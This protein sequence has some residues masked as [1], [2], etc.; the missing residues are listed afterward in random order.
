MLRNVGGRWR[1]KPRSFVPHETDEEA[2]SISGEQTVKASVIESTV[3]PSDSDLVLDDSWMTQLQSLDALVS[4]I[5]LARPGVEQCAREL[6]NK[7]LCVFADPQLD[8]AHIHL[9]LPVN[10]AGHKGELIS[11]VGWLLECVTGARSGELAQGT[12]FV[13]PC[14]VATAPWQEVSVK[15]GVLDRAIKRAQAQFP[16]QYLHQVR[17]FHLGPVRQH[18]RQLEPGPLSCSIRDRQLRML[19]TTERRRNVINPQA[20][21]MLEQLLN[22]PLQRLRSQL[23]HEAVQVCSVHLEGDPSQS[24]VVL[25]NTMVFHQPAH[26]DGPVVFWSAVKGLRVYNSLAVLEAHFNQW[27]RRSKEQHDWLALLAAEDRALVSSFLKRASAPLIRIETQAIED[28]FISELQRMEQR[29]QYQ[30]IE[31]ALLFAKRLLLDNAATVAVTHAVEIT[32]ANTTIL[33]TYSIKLQALFFEASLPDWIRKASD[34]ELNVYSELVAYYFRT[35][36]T[37]HDFLFGVPKLREFAREKLLM[38]LNI[39]F[40]NQTFDPDTIIV[41][42]FRYITAGTIGADVL[43]ALPAATEDYSET[44]TDFVLGHIGASDGFSLSVSSTDAQQTLTGFT[45]PYLNTLVRTLDIGGNYQNILEEKLSSSSADYAKRLG[46]FCD[47]LPAQM[48]ETAFQQKLEGILSNLAW[49]YV[50]RVVNMPDNLARLPVFGTTVVLRPFKLVAAPGWQADLASGIYLFGP[51]DSTQGPLVLHAIFHDAF[52]FKEFANEAELLLA[53][54]SDSELQELILQRLSPQARDRYDYGGFR[55][56]HL[57]SG[58]VTTWDS[59]PLIPAPPTLSQEAVEGNALQFFFRDTITVMKL[60]AKNQ[61]VTAA[62]AS[63]SA[64]TYLLTL[65]GEQAFT[66]LPGKL[67][68]LV[69]AWQSGSWFQASFTAASAQRWGKALSEFSAGLAM[70]LSSRAA[71]EEELVIDSEE[72]AQELSLPQPTDF[73]WQNNN[74]NAELNARLRTFEVIDVELKTL[75]KDPLLNLYGDHSAD[76]YYAAVG[77]KVFQVR[78]E[79]G[80][81]WI[82]DKEQSG[83][84]IR[85]DPLQHW[86]LDLQSGL[87]GGG[88]ILSRRKS[89]LTDEHVDNVFVTEA[90]GMPEIRSRYRERARQIGEGHLLAKR[91][92]QDALDNL[93]FPD[94]HAVLDDRVAD[95]IKAFFDVETVSQ[96]MLLLLQTKAKKL[97]DEILDASLSPFSSPRYV[98]GANKIGHEQTLG[99]TVKTDARKRIFFTERFFHTPSFRLVNSVMGRRFNVGAHHR[100]AILI[101]EVSHQVLDTHDITYVESS[102]PFNDLLSNDSLGLAILKRNLRDMQQVRLSWNTVRGELFRVYQPGGGWRD[103]DAMDGDGKAGILKVAGESSLEK[104]RDVFYSDSQKRC[105][106]MLLNADSVTLLMTKLG[107]QLFT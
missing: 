43:L 51:A 70:L 3:L 77:G 32:D 9:Q 23:G 78:Q 81:W 74:M 96:P 107:R 88:P 21:N 34:V 30:S 98:V 97:F 2:E 12:L 49:R 86:Q 91:Y 47:L 15:R 55:E 65:A 28:H 53:L 64:F 16:S 14:T 94:S 52:C 100:G 11:L 71:H 6:L 104:A 101:H 27:I 38:Q 80:Q 7:Q 85:L 83:P 62:Q 35:V 79:R 37:D 44:L 95:I 4:K 45:P 25:S 58:I 29:R 31:G 102:S 54:R 1:S 69:A 22:R 63:W 60:L 75:V 26:A 46:Y 92:V 48:F 105:E 90:S 17:Q 93:R 106:I 66:F 99:F 103:L 82:V 87:L 8:A 19:L 72:N 39:D 41:R 67:G 59:L 20:L 50:E 42:Y 68:S 89:S 13:V 10:D 40:P 33:D 61:T 5:S 18:D 73:S 57:P 24:V 56:P 84:P 36:I 76:K